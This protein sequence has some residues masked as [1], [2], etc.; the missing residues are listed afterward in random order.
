MFLD[1]VLTLGSN[2]T[3]ILPRYSSKGIQCDVSTVMRDA[4]SVVLIAEV[5]RSKRCTINDSQWPN[6]D[7]HV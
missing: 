5:H 3:Q 7:G 6:T 2:E 4:E 1:Y